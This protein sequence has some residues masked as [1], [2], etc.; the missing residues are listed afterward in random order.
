MILGKLVHKNKNK[1]IFGSR[2]SKENYILCRSLSN[3]VWPLL[4]YTL[5]ILP[6]V[7][8]VHYSRTNKILICISILRCGALNWKIILVSYRWAFTV[9]EGLPVST[10]FLSNCL[11]RVNP[12][13]SFSKCV[14]LNFSHPLRA[15]CL[16]VSMR[17]YYKR[18]FP[19]RP[20]TNGAIS[21][22]DVS[23]NSLR[24]R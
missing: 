16:A 22:S 18:M 24:S 13:K 6:A 7:F 17:V 21:T 4:I 5:Y 10:T 3:K 2:S 15:I 12:L 1:L 20:Q 19:R 8:R 11:F 9:L 23:M 14:R